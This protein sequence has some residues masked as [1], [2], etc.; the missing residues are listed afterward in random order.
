VPDT[1]PPAFARASGTPCANALD[2][3]LYDRFTCS[4]ERKMQ[5]ILKV[6]CRTE[7]SI[8]SLSYLAMGVLSAA[9]FAIAE[10][11]GVSWS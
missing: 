7:D 5:D 4:N 10:V 1:S 11:S 8:C 9:M 2:R 6:T 3:Q